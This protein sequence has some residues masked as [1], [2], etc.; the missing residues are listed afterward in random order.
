M[1]LVAAG[2]LCW[3][4][5]EPLDRLMRRLVDQQVMLDGTWRADYHALH[6]M[7]SAL[8]VRDAEMDPQG[9]EGW[10]W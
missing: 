2:D 7:L 5:S 9:L 6:A 3:K 1:M 8:P 4:N 10:A